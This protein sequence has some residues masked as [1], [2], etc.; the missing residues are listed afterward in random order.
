MRTVKILTEE[1]AYA[2]I[3]C[4]L[5]KRN[6]I[7]PNDTPSTMALKLQSMSAVADTLDKFITRDPLML[8]TKERTRKLAPLMDTVLII[9]PTGC[10]KEILAKALGGSRE[11]FLPLNCAAFN[12]GTVESELFGH[13]KGSFTD[14]KESKEGV[15]AAA[16]DGTVYLDEIDKMPVRIQAKLLRAIQEHE[17][18][19]I[20]STVYEPISCRFVASSK[21]PLEV[22]LEKH[23]F[24]ED[25]YARL[26]TFE[27]HVTGLLDRW[28]D[29]GVILRSML[30]AIGK[31]D[32]SNESLPELPEPWIPRVQRFN[33]RGI[34][35]Y[36]AQLRV[37]GE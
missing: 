12:D 10:G 31:W 36:V 25:L 11:G 6:G 16:G 27:L 17:I 33:V 35:S 37:F 28:D 23:G 14:A 15:L 8:D 5:V 32:S 3:W 22:L 19:R 4:D 20:G 9:G 26:S 7:T 30:I 2:E 34:E 13:T 21:I 24:L 1:E 29:V 18:R